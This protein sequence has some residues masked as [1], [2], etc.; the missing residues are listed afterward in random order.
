MARTTLASAI[1]LGTLA[2]PLAG[3]SYAQE[4]TA[5]GAA[6]NQ[7]Q[8]VEL[9]SNYEAKNLIGKDVRNDQGE[10]LGKIK[11]LVIDPSGRVTYAVLETGGIVGLG[12]KT[13]AIP[14][15]RIHVSSDRKHMTLNVSKD[16]ISSEFAAFEE[17][18]TKSE[19]REESRERNR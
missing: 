11:N 4:R 18:S 15:D 2:L 5:P 3:V 9:G 8:P 13:Y 7:M 19:H 10:K 16:Q 12:E 6:A 14:W 17:K 1:L